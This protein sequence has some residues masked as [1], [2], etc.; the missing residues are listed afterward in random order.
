MTSPL[1]LSVLI[2][3]AQSILSEQGDMKVWLAVSVAG[4]EYNEDHTVIAQDGD[5]TPKYY[6]CD[7]KKPL[8]WP[9]VEG[10]SGKVFLLYGW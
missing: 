5:T 2:E 7:P 9:E 10:I 8:H 3:K 1:M 4:Y 6:E